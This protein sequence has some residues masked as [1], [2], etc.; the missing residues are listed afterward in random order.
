MLTIIE[1]G[2]PLIRMSFI[3]N[4]DSFVAHSYAYTFPLRY[5][6]DIFMST[7]QNW[8]NLSILNYVPSI[9]LSN[10]DLDPK[11]LFLPVTVF[12]NVA[13]YFSVGLLARSFV[14]HNLALWMSGLFFYLFSP[15]LWNLGWFGELDWMPYGMWVALPLIVLSFKYLCDLEVNK[16][17]ISALVAQLIHPTFGILWAVFLTTMLIL[18]VKK[19]SL[20]QFFL[21]FSPFVL[22]GVNY[23]RTL[24]V[25][26]VP[27][28]RKYFEE[29]LESNGHYHFVNP[30][31][32][33]APNM[34]IRAWL[35]LLIFVG[36]GLLLTIRRRGFNPIFAYFTLYCLILIFVDQI[37]INLKYEPLI[38]LGGTR[39]SVA[40]LVIAC[41][42][43]VA[44]LAN[45][46][47]SGSGFNKI[48][49]T[50]LFMY[51]LPF[52]VLPYFV[53]IFFSNKLN[54]IKRNLKV[55]DLIRICYI[56]LFL[57]TIGTLIAF[58]HFNRFDLNNFF[59]YR[60]LSGTYLD[61]RSTFNAEYL[62]TPIFVNQR[63]AIIFLVV[64]SLLFI[65]FLIQKYIR[66]SI[67]FFLT[68]LI[69][70][71]AMGARNDLYASGYRAEFQTAVD[72][73]DSL[74]WINKNTPQDADFIA[75]LFPY[76][77][78]SITN[79]SV[80]WPSKFINSYMYTEELDTWNRE[81][82]DFSNQFYAESNAD[83]SEQNFMINFAQKQGV[84]FIWLPKSWAD[85][86]D[87]K[88]NLKIAHENNSYILYSLK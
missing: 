43:Y 35:F 40:L 74:I 68:C 83:K 66:I 82:E 10:F 36:F 21:L 79:R 59:Y 70:I 88:F 73:K 81:I 15:Q 4:D 32:S 38:L 60:Y 76:G 54:S 69:V 17:L 45:L 16:A 41:A 84:E 23:L 49:G 64:L 46:I 48:I 30:F 78:R 61:P 75:A 9:L 37:A 57:A 42:L 80:I 33:M 56:F 65:A 20:K 85:S 39:I 51:P 71:G 47:I 2:D 53:S 22:F 8:V 55:Y 25:D 12:Q 28:P 13:L 19:K 26:V 58:Y 11:V 52:L 14:K 34:T 29:I 62:W 44:Y 63:I 3:S 1:I 87:L 27:K 67:A 24:S 5:S 50:L 7:F 72:R 6:D 31:D 18:Q 86:K 77:F